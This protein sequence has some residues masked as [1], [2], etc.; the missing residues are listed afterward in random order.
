MKKTFREQTERRHCS[1]VAEDEAEHGKTQTETSADTENRDFNRTLNKDRIESE[2]DT[3]RPFQCLLFF[4]R[5]L[6]LCRP[7]LFPD[8]AHPD[9]WVKSGPRQTGTGANQ[10]VWKPAALDKSLPPHSSSADIASPHRG[11]LGSCSS[12]DG[13]CGARDKG[14][15]HTSRTMAAISLSRSDRRQGILVSVRHT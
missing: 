14:I 3:H 5:D 11:Q 9:T 10:K 15:G 1:N 13:P 12:R 8:P 4:L 2:T 6:T 7:H